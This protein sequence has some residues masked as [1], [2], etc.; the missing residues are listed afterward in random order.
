MYIVEV[1]MKL[2]VLDLMDKESFHTATL[3]CIR[4]SLLHG[5][6]VFVHQDYTYMKNV[7][8]KYLFLLE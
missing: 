6:F 2:W 7:L 5:K 1:C 3:G 4:D 8:N